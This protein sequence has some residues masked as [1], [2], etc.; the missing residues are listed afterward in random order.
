MIDLR[1]KIWKKVSEHKSI[2]S[3]AVWL[4]PKYAKSLKD[5]SL[6]DLKT[7]IV[8][9]NNNVKS[10]NTL[11]RKLGSKG[12][13]IIRTISGAELNRYR[14][15]EQKGY[16]QGLTKEENNELKTLEFKVAGNISDSEAQNVAKQALEINAELGNVRALVE[17]NF[18]RLK[19]A[20]AMEQYSKAMKEGQ[21]KMATKFKTMADTAKNVLSSLGMAIEGFVRG[22]LKKPAPS[23][24]KKIEYKPGEKAGKDFTA[25]DEN[26]N[27]KKRVL[28]NL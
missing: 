20:Y 28:S 16:R 14:A 27:W 13:P 6:E 11:L 1:K 3:T 10:L 8:S 24:A 19:H 9:W 26:V 5:I 17:G 21:D 25:K 4:D 22:F 23:D 18:N 7:K 2:G 12:D 15:L